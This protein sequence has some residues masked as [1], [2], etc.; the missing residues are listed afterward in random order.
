MTRGDIEA[1]A[2][3][4]PESR[5]SAEIA[6]HPARVVLQD[7]TGVPAVVDLAAMRD[8]VTALGG[9]PSRINPLFPSELVIDHSIQVDFPARRSHFH[10]TLTRNM[11][12]MVNAM[13][14]SGGLSRRS[15]TSK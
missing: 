12:E 6:M 13:R 15:R 10:S 14:F 11:A 9:D 2:N 4:V 5:P 7:F 1:I 3:W 8:A